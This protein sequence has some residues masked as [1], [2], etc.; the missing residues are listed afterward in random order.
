MLQLSCAAWIVGVAA[1]VNPCSGC[2]KLDVEGLQRGLVRILPLREGSRGLTCHVYGV[3]R[4]LLTSILFADV[5]YLE[6]V[7]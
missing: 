7:G 5:A 2:S 1:R 4:R 6:S 3:S